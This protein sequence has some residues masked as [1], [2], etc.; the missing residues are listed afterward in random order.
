MSREQWQAFLEAAM[1]W[2]PIRTAKQVVSHK[3]AVRE[4]QGLEGGV[5]GAAEEGEDGEA[6][7]R[8]FLEFCA[9][10]GRYATFFYSAAAM[11]VSLAFEPAPTRS[12]Y[13]MAPTRRSRS[14]PRLHR[15]RRPWGVSRPDP[16]PSPTPKPKP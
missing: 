11:E 3:V 5:Q 9:T 10:L 14:S 13:P 4:S 8:T 7:P 16:D 6:P 15:R 12:L 2:E 1:L